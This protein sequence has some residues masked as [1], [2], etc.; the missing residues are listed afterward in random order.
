MKKLFLLLTFFITHYTFLIA[1]QYGWVK[2]ATLG[3]Q[4]TGLSTVEFIDTLHGWTGN[5]FGHIAKTSDGGFNWNLSNEVGF[6]PK[7]IS[8]FDTLIGWAVGNQSFSDG[9]I[10]KTTNGGD[11]WFIQYE[12][13]YHQI[14]GTY[15]RNRL[16]NITSVSFDTGKTVETTNGG[17]NW[18]E[19]II[20][21]S[22]TYLGKIQF[23]DSLHGWIVGWTNNFPAILRT[24]DGGISWD[25]LPTPTGFGTIS[26]I[27][28]LNG[29]ATR[30]QATFSYRTFD[31]GASWQRL[32]RIDTADAQFDAEALSFVDSLNGWAF[33]N[34]YFQ[35]ADVGA[36]FHTS[37]GGVSWKLE[38]WSYSPSGFGGGQM[39]N[40]HT[41]WAV[42][43]GGSVLAY[44]SLTSV[45]E[46]LPEI[47]KTFSLR[48][49]Y[50][51][52]FNAQTNI[53][54]ELK[55]SSNVTLT[56]FDMKGKQVL[57]L[58]NS[59]QNTGVYRVRFDG[60]ALASGTYFYTLQTNSFSDT[61]QMILI[62]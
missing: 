27:D 42:G 51:N 59:E 50:P 43:G 32:G 19:H 3:N 56:I 8:M 6:V 18:N 15:T 46:Q 29:W 24:R 34:M 13:D 28:T 23:L 41:G 38:Y 21:D 61:K 10:Y 35:H 39:L 5:V 1:Q 55:Q 53:E 58:I 37:D 11:L 49:N 40:K 22:I 44:K 14:F 7:S 31:G 4:T 36:I 2:I 45:V 48:Q 33:G 16:R 54:Y 26:F 62:K 60:T 25:I 20:A 30:P 47:P 52:P 12:S 17:T 57:Q 9:R